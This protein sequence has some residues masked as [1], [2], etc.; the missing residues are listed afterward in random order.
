[1][2]GT[3][4]I[5]I[6]HVAVTDSNHC[7]GCKGEY[8]EDKAHLWIGCDFNESHW[9]HYNCAEYKRKPSTKIT[10]QCSLC[11][12]G[13]SQCFNF[14]S[15]VGLKDEPLVFISTQDSSNVRCLTSL[16]LPSCPKRVA[17]NC[18]SKPLLIAVIFT[19][20]YFTLKDDHH[21]TINYL[22]NHYITSIVPRFFPVSCKVL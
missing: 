15:E 1:M 20:I 2:Y 4:A 13:R 17:C 11:K 5:N 19:L 14:I 10:F 16:I 12:T 3:T 18:G 21:Y 8:T 22:H 9:W 7:P 6:T